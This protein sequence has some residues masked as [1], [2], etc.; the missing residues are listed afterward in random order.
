MEP[1]TKTSRHFSTNSEREIYVDLSFLR[2]AVTKSVFRQ[3]P[4]VDIVWYRKR[5]RKVRS[6]KSEVSMRAWRTHERCFARGFWRDSGN[7][8]SDIS[9]IIKKNPAIGFV[10]GASLH[11]WFEC[12]WSNEVWSKEVCCKEPCDRVRIGF[13][14]SLL[15]W[16]CLKKGSIDLGGRLHRGCV[17]VGRDSVNYLHFLYPCWN[18]LNQC[19][20]NIL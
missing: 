10:S 18:S 13:I 12:V 5:G 8:A 7:I 14:F 3:E 20:I 15:F 6:A 17:H 4:G 2:K 1:W 16:M 9:H 11:Y 19:N